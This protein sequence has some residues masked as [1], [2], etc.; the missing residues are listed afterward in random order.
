MAK[1][2]ADRIAVEITNPAPGGH[3]KTS[4]AHARRYVKR[5]IATLTGGLLTFHRHT[6][7]AGRATLRHSATPDPV[8]IA[9]EITDARPD[10]PILPPTPEWMQRMGYRVFA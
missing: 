6:A 3:T 8:G 1:C 9:P 2:K 10:M 7:D 5:G 4:L